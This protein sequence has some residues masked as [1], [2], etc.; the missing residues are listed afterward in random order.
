MPTA[1]SRWTT[2]NRSRKPPETEVAPP[3]KKPGLRFANGAYGSSFRD[4]IVTNFF[5]R[6][7]NFLLIAPLTPKKGFRHQTRGGCPAKFGEILFFVFINPY[8]ISPL[9][10]KK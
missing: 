7:P 5:V 3:R 2:R 1:N 4:W 8:L 9:W 6:C 10:P